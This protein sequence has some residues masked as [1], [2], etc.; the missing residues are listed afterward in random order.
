MLGPVPSHNMY[1]Y[2]PQ[3]SYKRK[4]RTYDEVGHPFGDEFVQY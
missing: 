1:D 3:G 4:P 2:S